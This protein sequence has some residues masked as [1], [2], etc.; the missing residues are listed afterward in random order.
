MWPCRGRTALHSPLEATLAPGPGGHLEADLL[1]RQ[2]VAQLL[3][4]DGRTFGTLLDQDLQVGLDSP[5][6]LGRFLGAPG[7]VRSGWRTAESGGDE[8]R[9]S[10]AVGQKPD[11]GLT[12]LGEAFL[13]RQSAAA[14]LL[15]DRLPVVAMEVLQLDQRTQLLLG[16]PGGGRRRSERQDGGTLGEETAW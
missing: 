9:P 3:P 13:Q 5:S 12:Q 6:Q 1:P 11:C 14:H 15:R 4:T 16:E 2:V 10:A 8:R 7:S